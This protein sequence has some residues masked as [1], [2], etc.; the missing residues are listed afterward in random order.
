[1]IK[2]IN[3]KHPQKVLKRSE[4][5]KEAKK[6]GFLSGIAFIISAVI[7]VGIFLKNGQILS[8]NLGNFTLTLMAWLLAS[9][10][11]ISLGLS[12]LVIAAKTNSELGILQ[13]ARDFLSPGMFQAIKFYFLFLY[14][15]LI[16]SGDSYYFLQALQQAFPTWHLRWYITWIVTFIVLVYFITVNTL[17]PKMILVH[18]Y[19]AFY[20]KLI[21]IIFFAVVAFIL[22]FIN[23]ENVKEHSDQIYN[24]FINFP[25]DELSSFFYTNPMLMYGPEIGFFLSIPAMFFAYD[26]FYYVVSIR[27][28]L[29]EPK[30]AP[31]IILMGIIAVATIFILITLSLLLSTNAYSSV[32]GTILGV[33]YLHSS[34]VWHA[35]NSI[36]NI[37]ICIGCLGI[38][39][40]SLNFSLSL[41]KEMLIDNNLPFA[42][43][44][45]NKTNWSI[46]KLSFIYL[47]SYIFVFMLILSVVGTFGFLNLD[48]YNFGFTPSAKINQLYSFINTITNWESLFTFATFVFII[49]GSFVAM[50]KKKI[51]FKKTKKKVLFI[52]ESTIGLG[53]IGFAV[54]FSMLHALG[55]VIIVSMHSYYYDQASSFYDLNNLNGT[56]ICIDKNWFNIKY[57]NN[58]LIFQNL[59]HDNLNIH[60]LKMIKITEIKSNMHNVNPYLFALIANQ[61]KWINNSIDSTLITNIKNYHNYL[62]NKEES[63]YQNLHQDYIGQIINFI[64]LLFIISSCITYAFI[65]RFLIKK[66]QWFNLPN[67]IFYKSSLEVHL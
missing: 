51:T 22:Y 55:N 54:L 52:I 6:I 63:I 42:K 26:G 58:T 29:R 40:S 35:I 59:Q 50:K 2:T 28:Q 15:P 32:R 12:L 64:I 56:Q 20:I 43:W 39:S 67:N 62:F 3:K 41:Y 10:A 23:Y 49:G 27:K 46:N 1:M 30:K 34:K 17:V 36:L 66:N 57:I 16:I 33:S 37:A 19:V 18:A 53:V 4:N 44:I 48:G 7:G 65:N 8:Y 13:W 38:I 25:R 60:N 21:P 14:I 47:Y 31:N 61:Q 5:K 45:L 24:G 11:V 9:V